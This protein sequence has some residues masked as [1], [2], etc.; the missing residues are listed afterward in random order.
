MAG[1][2]VAVVV[3]QRRVLFN[4]LNGPSIILKRDATS[5]DYCVRP[6]IHPSIRNRVGMLVRYISNELVQRISLL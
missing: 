1:C 4:K 2:L 5:T 3:N 6:S